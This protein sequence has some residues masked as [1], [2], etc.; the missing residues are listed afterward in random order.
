VYY[1]VHWTVLRKPP[2]NTCIETLSSM[3]VHHSDSP[4]PI[5]HQS[6]V[7]QTWLFEVCNQRYFNTSILYFIN[8][9]FHSENGYVF[10]GLRLKDNLPYREQNCADSSHVLPNCPISLSTRVKR[11]ESYTL[12][13]SAT[14]MGTRCSYNVGLF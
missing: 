13:C 6:T 12:F 5:T 14:L 3:N 8:T 4:V 10:N 2:T 11:D 9:K 7:N 1:S